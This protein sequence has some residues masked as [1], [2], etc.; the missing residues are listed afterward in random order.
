M[1]PTRTQCNM[2]RLVKLG[3]TAVS[4]WHILSEN[5]LYFTPLYRVWKWGLES[6][7]KFQMSW[8][9]Y[10]SLISSFISRY[11]LYVIIKSLVG[12][13]TSSVKGVTTWN[14]SQRRTLLDVWKSGLWIFWSFPPN[15]KLFWAH[16][17]TKSVFSH[18]SYE[19]TSV[20]IY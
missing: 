20:T 18:K 14:T 3:A 6:F 16:T 7:K 10:S 5:N 17:F 12:P 19:C 13:L 1:L 11:V 9:S 4:P 15:W 8:I 2:E